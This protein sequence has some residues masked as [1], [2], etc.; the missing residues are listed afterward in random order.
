MNSHQ[1]CLKPKFFSKKK[2]DTYHD[3]S[4]QHGRGGGRR[5]GTHLKRGVRLAQ[6]VGQAGLGP[7]PVVRGSGRARRC[8]CVRRPVF[9]QAVHI[10]VAGRGGRV[11][12]ADPQVIHHQLTQTPI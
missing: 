11:R 3:A 9:V 1:R 10:V 6:A 8:V 5:G 12:H 7:H 2:C 4:A